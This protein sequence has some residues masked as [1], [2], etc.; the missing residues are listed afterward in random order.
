[1]FLPVCELAGHHPAA[2]YAAGV[3]VRAAVAAEQ[4]G[5]GA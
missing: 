5:S 1:M 3:A 4:S 2:L